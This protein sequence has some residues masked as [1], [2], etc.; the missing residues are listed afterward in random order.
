MLK[1]QWDML[2]SIASRHLMGARA[3]ERTWVR[4]STDNLVSLRYRQR[5]RIWTK[6]I[7]R[8]FVA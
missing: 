3:S 4:T 2:V 6:E 8:Y 1:S 5:R 7:G